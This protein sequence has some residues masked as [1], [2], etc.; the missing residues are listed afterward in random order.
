MGP[1][2]QVGKGRRQFQ[3]EPPLLGMPSDGLVAPRLVGFPVCADEE[4]GSLP[5]LPPLRL[6]ESRLPEMVAAPG[7][8][9]SSPAH[10]HP[11]LRQ[12]SFNVSQPY[13]EDL[14]TALLL[15]ALGPTRIAPGPFPAL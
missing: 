4:A 3:L 7:K 9:A 14:E 1:V 5:P 10:R 2:G 8:A 11:A 12:V 6:G 15:K 13:F